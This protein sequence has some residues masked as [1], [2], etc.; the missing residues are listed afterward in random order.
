MNE[1]KHGDVP[2]EEAV[3]EAP[4]RRSERDD[5]HDQTWR[6]ETLKRP[7]VQLPESRAGAGPATRGC[8]VVPNGEPVDGQERPRAITRVARLHQY[9]R[10]FVELKIVRDTMFARLAKL[11]GRLSLTM[12]QVNTVVV[13]VHAVLV[14][15]VLLHEVNSRRSG[16]RTSFVCSCG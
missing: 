16:P 7:A 6:G 12:T 10:T 15:R 3:A 8:R 9:V 11:A 14:L 1:S 2:G 5:E 13:T 4:I